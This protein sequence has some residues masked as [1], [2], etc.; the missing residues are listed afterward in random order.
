VRIPFR[1]PRYLTLGRGDQA[2]RLYLFE[3]DVPG[4]IRLEAKE[5]GE[6]GNKLFVTA[7]HS[8]PAQFDVTVQFDGDRFENARQVVLGDP[9]PAL[10]AALNQPARVG[11]LQAK[12]GGIRGAVRRA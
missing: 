2:A 12:A 9:V 6:P 1:K 8:G 10:S 7:R 11:V 4:F 3:D 5:T